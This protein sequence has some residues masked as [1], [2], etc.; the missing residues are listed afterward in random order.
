MPRHP[1]AH[2]AAAGHPNRGAACVLIHRQSLQVVLPKPERM[3][4][5]LECVENKIRRSQPRSPKSKLQGKIPG[6]G[7]FSQPQWW[8]QCSLSLRLPTSWGWVVLL[9]LRGEELKTCFYS[10]EACTMTAAKEPRD[11][12]SFCL[13]TSIFKTFLLR[14]ILNIREDSTMNPHV[15]VAQ[16]QQWPT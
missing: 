4:M 10:R 6:I 7:T 11:I 3:S 2:P 13:N 16:F 5:S 15:S 12:F 1:A 9:S 8:R 14:R